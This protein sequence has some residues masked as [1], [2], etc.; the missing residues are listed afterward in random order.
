MKKIETEANI[1]QKLYFISTFNLFYMVKIKRI[2]THCVNELYL[3]HV[4]IAL[5][6]HLRNILHRSFV[7]FSEHFNAL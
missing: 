6:K 4:R 2:H 3:I 7:E 5:S 1:K